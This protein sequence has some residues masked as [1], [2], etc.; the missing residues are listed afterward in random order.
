M[1]LPLKCLSIPQLPTVKLS[2]LI[3]TAE[4]V[5]T[6][7]QLNATVILDVIEEPGIIVR[8]L[9]A[10]VRGI[11]LTYWVDLCSDKIYDGKQNYLR[12]LMSL[13]PSGTTVLTG[14]NQFP[15]H[16]HLPKDLPSSYESAFGS[17][18]YSV[19]VKLTIESEKKQLVESFPFFVISSSSFDEIPQSLMRPICCKTDRDFTVCS[20]PFGRVFLKL[21]VPRLAYQLGEIITPLVYVRNSARTTLSDCYVQ[22]IMKV[23]YEASSRYEHVNENKVIENRVCESWLG[24]IKSHSEMVSFKCRLE[25]PEDIP[26]NTLNDARCIIKISYV[27]RLRAL[28]NVEVEIPLIVTAQGYKEKANSLIEPTSTRDFR[29]Q[30][31]QT[32]EV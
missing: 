3:P 8:E 28:P 24:R 29:F 6:G 4:R 32:V 16:F 26:P 10:E 14:R 27:L 31:S 15:F 22:L 23:Q 7:S 21:S 19:R 20:L 18:R 9:I 25:T 2:L 13:C 11:A 12:N 17:I 1:L 5:L 30:R